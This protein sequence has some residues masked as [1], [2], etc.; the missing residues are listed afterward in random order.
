M[1]K[2]FRIFALIYEKTDCGC[3]TASTLLVIHNM[4][5]KL[6]FTRIWN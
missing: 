1:R 4:D 5:N 3:S 2:K 6:K